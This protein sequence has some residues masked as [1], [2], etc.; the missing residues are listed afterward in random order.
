M[1]AG[2]KNNAEH[3]SS[4]SCGG[5][6]TASNFHVV[7][8][9]RETKRIIV[10]FSAQRRHMSAVFRLGKLLKMLLKRVVLTIETLSEECVSCLEQWHT[11]WLDISVVTM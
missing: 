3:V 7:T 6:G 10:S 2:T 5:H 11:I 1:D 9:T 4:P 8:K